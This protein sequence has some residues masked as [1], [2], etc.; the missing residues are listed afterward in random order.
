MARGDTAA[1]AGHATRVVLEALPGLLGVG[2]VAVGAGMAWLPAGPIAAG[3]LIV[4]DRL[5]D[6]LLEQRAGRDPE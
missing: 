2:L 5:L 6:R 4:L 1:A 3:G